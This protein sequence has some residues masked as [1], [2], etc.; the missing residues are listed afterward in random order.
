MIHSS[1]PE[2]FSAQS[3]EERD[4]GYGSDGATVRVIW[5]L[6][7]ERTSPRVLGGCEVG[8]FMGSGAVQASTAY[9]QSW[10]APW[11]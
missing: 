5:S 1:A 6:R 3:R 11:K 4:P 2:P 9:A 7:R 8:V 10:W